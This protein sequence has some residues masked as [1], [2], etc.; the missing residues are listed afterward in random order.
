MQI[1]CKSPFMKALTAII[2]DTRRKKANKTYPVKLR[3]TYL[4]KQIYYPSRFDLLKE[5]FD[6]LFSPKPRD[7]YKKILLELISIE[8]KAKGIIDELKGNFTWKAFDAKFLKK[9]SDWNSVFANYA[10]CIKKLREDNRIGNAVSYEC[11]LNSLKEYTEKAGGLSFEDITIEFLNKYES[12]ML[13]NGRSITTVGIYL[14][15]LRAIFN[16]A[17]QAGI[18]SKDAYPFGKNK[19]EIPT[20]K[21]IKKALTIDNVGKIYHYTPENEAEAQARDFWLLSYFGNGMNIKDIALLKFRNIQGDIIVFE[22]AKTRRSR[23]GNPIIITIPLTEDVKRIID[24]WGNKRRTQDNY[25]F[26]ILENGLTAE[27]ERVLIQQFT[28]TINKYMNR[29][30]GTLEID[31]KVTTYTA[32][33]SFSTVL[34]RSGASTEFISEALGHADIKTTR[35]Y[36]DSFENEQK[37]EIAKALTAFKKQY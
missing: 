37:R 31:K 11:S 6:K 35:N 5:D 36:L 15:A 22:R 3:V 1:V 12:W 20:G 2:L 27:R 25:I 29:I 4:R 14:R 28:K 16:E 23:R 8:N 9:Q 26:P 24:Q 7:Q 34:K 10:D 32:R 30:A 18:I 17:I 19:Y 13:Q 33:H 21:N